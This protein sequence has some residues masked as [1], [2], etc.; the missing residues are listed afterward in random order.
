MMGTWGT[1]IGWSVF[2]AL[3]I[4]IGGFWGIAQGEWT[5]TTFK[6]R[7]L[8]YYGISILLAAILIFAYSGTK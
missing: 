8:A 6:V 2:I 4:A 5:K 7:K 1:V 3:S